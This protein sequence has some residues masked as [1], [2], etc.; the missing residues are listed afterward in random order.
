M[1]ERGVCEGYECL[2]CRTEYCHK[3][4]PCPVCQLAKAEKALE[5][6]ERA[7]REAEDWKACMLKCAEFSGNMKL[8]KAIERTERAMSGSGPPTP[9]A[10]E[11]PKAESG[12]ED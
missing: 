4:R 7:R 6:S 5:A 11:P 1:R 8:S 12:E 3:Y 10:T 9:K 2:R